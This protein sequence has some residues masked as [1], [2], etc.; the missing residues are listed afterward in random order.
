MIKLAEIQ[1]E[2]HVLDLGC[3]IGTLA[4]MASQRTSGQIYG[5][6][7]SNERLELARTK[8]PNGTTNVNFVFGNVMSMK[9]GR[10]KIVV[11]NNIKFNVVFVSIFLD[12]STPDK[13]DLK[14]LLQRVGSYLAQNARI[15]LG[16]T[17]LEGK[18]GGYTAGGVIYDSR[19]HQ[20]FVSMEWV[21]P[22]YRESCLREFRDI[23]DDIG[24]RVFN[25]AQL[26][27]DGGQCENIKSGFPDFIQKNFPATFL[28]VSEGIV[29]MPQDSADSEGGNF[30]KFLDLWTESLANTKSDGKVDGLALEAHI[31]N[32]IIPK[33]SRQEWNRGDKWRIHVLPMWRRIVNLIRQ[34]KGENPDWNINTT[35]DLSLGYQACGAF[36]FS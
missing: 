36:T 21:H 20:K 33:M 13:E 35:V 17:W 27:L 28:K 10:N 2:E 1:S 8:V 15:I 26:L 14:V 12:K 6:D 30:D 9:D 11:P 5:I 34:T 29:Q 23:C 32:G 22:R 4:I 24:L 18:A 19:S 31:R 3:G 25:P 7:I 16:W